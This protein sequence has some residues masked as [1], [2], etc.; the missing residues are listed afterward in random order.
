MST[1]AITNIGELVTWDRRPARPARRRAGG[2]GRAG[3]LGRRRRRHAGRRRAWS[4]PAAARSSPASSTPTPTW[5]SPATGR[6]SS[7]P[8]WPGERYDGRRHPHDGRRDPGRRRG[9]SSRG[10]PARRLAEMRA[11][12]TTTVEIKSGYGLDVATEERAAAG[13]VRA[14]R[15]RPPSSAR[16]SCPDGWTADDYVD[17]VTG[18]MLDACA[19][20]ARWIDVFC[21]TGAFDADQARTVLTRR[22]R[23]RAAAPRPRQPARPRPRRPAGL[24]AGR[25]RRRPLHL[26]D[27]RRRRR[28]WPTP[29]WSP[30]CCP[31][32]EFSTRHPYP[33]AR[34]LL[35]AGVRSRSPP[36]A[37]RA[38]PTRR[39]MPFCIALA[40]REMGMTPTE[41]LHA[42][43]AGGARVAAPRRR[44]PPAP[45]APG[46]TW[47][48]WTRPA[49]STSPTAPASRWCRASFT[50]P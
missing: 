12:G 5:S 21:E 11:Q 35:D 37:T 7:P 40:V 45:S 8:G 44:R 27:R 6:R 34:R 26:P 28:R 16:T 18:Q 29:A 36:T 46:P 33:D 19:P 48:S 25:G 2:R 3:R 13:G 31:G 50:A 14:H 4:T 47:C 43:T 39:S 41:A 30:G 42:A 32:V 23:R 10:S 17:L 20:H 24:R 9:T 49:T 22:H 1:V 15:R 38:R